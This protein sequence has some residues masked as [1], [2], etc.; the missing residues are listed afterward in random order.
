M[1]SMPRVASREEWLAARQDLLAQEKELTRARDALN[2][3]RRQLGMVKIEKQYAFE[4]PEGT[5]GLADLF[6][7]CR[8]LVIQHFMFDPRWTDGCPS[9]TWAAGEISEGRLQH[10]RDWETAFAAVSRAPLPKLGG[11]KRRRG[12]RFPWHSSNGSDFNYDFQVTLDESV[13]PAVYNYR[14]KDENERRGEAE[15]LTQQPLELP[16]YSCFL[17]DGETVFHTYSTY[18]RGTESIGGSQYVVDLTVLGRQQESE[19]HYG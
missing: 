16:G 12:W 6:D 7:G 9:C 3:R 2:G 5:V 15:F 13:A 14:A 17:R 10:L 19:K 8:Q 4:G 18:A 1:M 11:Y